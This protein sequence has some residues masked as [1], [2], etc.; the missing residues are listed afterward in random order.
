MES[1][2]YVIIVQGTNIVVLSI[3][4]SYLI[5]CK[6]LRGNTE[7]KVFLLSFPCVLCGVVLIIFVILKLY[8]LLLNVFS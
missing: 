3:A 8:I 4:I 2:L 7:I 6:K 5:A 1:F